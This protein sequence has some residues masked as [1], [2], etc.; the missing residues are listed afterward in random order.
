[1]QDNSRE[2]NLV[3]VLVI[4]QFFKPGKSVCETGLACITVS[5]PHK[6]LLVQK[7]TV[8]PFPDQRYWLKS[9][10]S[11][12]AELGSIPRAVGVYRAARASRRESD[13][14]FESD[15]EP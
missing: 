2:R 6:S 5:Q 7:Y 10:K 12:S 9:P 11:L 8:F 3:A 4:P 14:S 15:I 13:S 1:M